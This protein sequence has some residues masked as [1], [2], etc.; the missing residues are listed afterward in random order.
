MIRPLFPIFACFLGG[1]LLEHALRIHE[2]PFYDIS[3]SVWLLLY[4]VFFLLAYTGYRT[5]QARLTTLLVLLLAFLTGA[6]RYAASNQ[7]PD[8]HIANLVDDDL[9]TVEGCLY[10][11]VES[12]RTLRYVYVQTSWLEKGSQRYRVTGKIRIMLTR[13]A[14][15]QPEIKPLCYGDTIRARLRLSPPQNF[16]MFDYREFLRQRGIYLIGTL[17]HERNLLKIST[18][19]GSPVMKLMYGLQA[20]MQQFL[21]AY[22]RR[23]IMEPGVSPGNIVHAIQVIQAMTLGKSRQLDQE[24]KAMFRQAGMYHLLVISGVHIGILAWGG[25]KILNFL[26]VPLQYRSIVLSLIL[27]VYAGVTGFQFPVL[28]AV[29]MATVF[30]LS[31][32]CNRIADPVYSLLFTI[33]LILFLFPN[34]LFEVSF[35]LTVAAT[36]SILLFFRFLQGM[37]WTNRLHTL[38]AKWRLPLISLLATTGA[39]IGVAP[40]LVYYFGELSPYSF[41]S[42]PAALPLISLLLPSCLLAN[43]LSLIIPSWT[44][45]DPLIS[46]NVWLTGWLIHLSGIFPAF[47]IRIPRPS[48]LLILI[49]YA[50]LFCLFHFGRRIG[51]TGELW[52]SC[53]SRDSW[54]RPR[55]DCLNHDW[56]DDEQNYW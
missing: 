28:R 47:A 15:I 35:Q 50:I 56:C 33:W 52:A 19:Q 45:L 49:Y 2:L 31:I 21:D 39:M 12:V 5:Q 14:W 32:T 30:Y 1:M 43:L 27:V 51:K 26:R 53:P 22:T 6:T 9:V 48:G 29:I 24:I 17:H 18:Q 37:Q 8:H 42:N 46:L 4:G 11:P 16:D 10:R 7:I 44:L 25:H 38:P 55:E 34:S 41:I 3:L 36:A 13:P 23:R 20:R 54:F 40:L